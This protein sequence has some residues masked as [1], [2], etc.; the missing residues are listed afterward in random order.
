V[1][2]KL[3]FQKSSFK[4]FVFEDMLLPRGGTVGDAGPGASAV[5]AITD[6]AS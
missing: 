5:L 6:G 1:I 2:V 4:N 3:V